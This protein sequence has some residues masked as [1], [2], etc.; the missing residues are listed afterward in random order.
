MTLRRRIARLGK[1]LHVFCSS[2]HQCG[3][4]KRENHQSKAQS[5]QGTC[6]GES[7][8][9]DGAVGC[10]GHPLINCDC[11][12]SHRCESRWW[13][14]SFQPLPHPSRRPRWPF[15]RT[16][17]SRRRWVDALDA[18][19]LKGRCAVVFALPEWDW[20]AARHNLWFVM[21][22][23]RKNRKWSCCC[24]HLPHVI[25]CISKHPRG[26]ILPKWTLKVISFISPRQNQ[27]ETTP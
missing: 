11:F 10:R 8:Q 6:C 12:Q 13:W 19:E 3:I 16:D 27:N 5:T 25:I 21:K 26:K 2:G 24:V 17:M 22:A 1:H 7:M 23:D 20:S 9:R 14:P 15:M 4:K 18:G